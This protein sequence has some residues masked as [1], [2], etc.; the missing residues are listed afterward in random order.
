MH[1]VHVDK[2]VITCDM[3][4][5]NLSECGSRLEIFARVHDLKYKNVIMLPG[6]G[7]APSTWL[8][9]SH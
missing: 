9:Q 3:S 1:M 4:G 7:P 5:I 6:H 2:C 8:A